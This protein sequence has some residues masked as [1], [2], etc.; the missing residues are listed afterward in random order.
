MRTVDCPGVGA[1][2]ALGFGCAS[3]GSRISE[4]AGRAAIDAALKAGITWFDAA[5]SYGDGAAERILG[6]ALKGVNASIVTKAGLIAGRRNPLKAAIGAVARPVVAAIP[7]LR[8]LVKKL[9]PDAAR[10]LPLDA[11]TLRTSLLQSLE[12]LGKT[13]L[14]VFALHD[15]SLEDVTNEAVIRALDDIKT[16]GLAARI[17]IAGDPAIFKAALK[18]GLPADTL[19]TAHS[20]FTNGLA[21]AGADVFTITHSVFGV[22]G[23]LDRLSRVPAERLNGA[24]FR[25]APSALLAYAFASNPNGVVLTS[26][27]APSH[28]ATNAAA[29]TAMPDPAVVARLDALLA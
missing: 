15:P 23:A 13:D 7:S 20:P 21:A 3:L 8:P 1:V 17:A 26:S 14:A 18:A 12:R 2:S 11:E 4:K 10:R 29:A 27:F 16:Q 9:R 25:D 6:D 5:P 28:L 22:A 19:Q 24:G